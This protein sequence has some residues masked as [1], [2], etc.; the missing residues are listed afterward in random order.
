MSEFTH[1][2][3]EGRAKMVNVGDKAF[4]DRTAVARGE[5]IMQPETIEKIK[6]GAM[7]KGDVLGVA[8]V[9]GI[10]GAKKT[11]ELIPM[12]HNIFPAKDIRNRSRQRR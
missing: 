3:A 6:K 7:K 10:A 8:Q 12:C 9:A 11:W 4:T 5:V 2:N 1:I